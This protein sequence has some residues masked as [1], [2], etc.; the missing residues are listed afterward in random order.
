M[1]PMEDGAFPSGD[2]FMI[3]PG[4]DGMPLE[5][6]RLVIFHEALQDLA[7]LQLLERLTSREHVL[8]LMSCD[9]MG[10]PVEPISFTTYPTGE[11]YLLGLGTV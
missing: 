6:Q 10:N 4:A 9:D 7:A 8:A 1:K 11:A 5:S 2:A 3:Y